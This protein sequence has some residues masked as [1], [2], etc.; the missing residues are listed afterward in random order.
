[1]N[2]RVVN[3]G[4]AGKRKLYPTDKNPWDI[5]DHAGQDWYE[6]IF[7]Y[8]EEHKKQLNEKGTLAGI[9]DALTDRLVWDLDSKE[10]LEQAKQ[11]TIALCHRLLSYGVPEECISLC[12]SGSKGF[13]VV[14]FTDKEFN[15]G[16]FKA[17]NLALAGDL[18]TNDTTV[19]DTQ[20]IFRIPGTKHQVTGLFKIPVSLEMLESKSI[21]EIKELAKDETYIHSSMSN[22]PVPVFN[23]PDNIYKL[24]N[25]TASKK[26]NVEIIDVSDLDFNKK[27]RGFTNCK[28]AIMNGFF[29]EGCRSNALTALAA[30][31]RAQGFS[32][33]TTWGIVKSAIRQQAKRTNTEP[34]GK[35][36]AW[37]TII[38]STYSAT[39]DGGQYSC[40]VQP[41]LTEI[42]ESLGVHKCKHNNESHTISSDD[43][44]GLFSNYAE[45]YDENVL[46]TGIDELDKESKFLVGTS[47]G[48][49]A[50]PGVG[51]TSIALGILNHN[52]NQ[53]IHSV[54]FSYDMFHSALYLR[55]IQRH[56][57]LRQDKIFDIFKHDKKQVNK[58]REILKEEYKNVHFCFKSGQSPDEI[59]QTIVETEQ[60]FGKVKLTII[61][62]NE[63]VVASSSDPTQASAQTAQRLRQIA[64]DRETCVITLLQPNKMNSNPSNEAE[65]YQAA[66]GSNAIAQSVTLML[67]LSRP[68]FSTRKTEQDKFFSINA[69]KNRMG[70]LFAKDFYWDGLT[71]KIRS[72]T[73]EE[74]EELRNLKK[75]KEA[76]KDDG[77]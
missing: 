59:E 22:Y 48:I 36:E 21:E 41:W 11:D 73:Y 77:Y 23:L 24:K 18:S 62:Y 13:S 51:K 65:T 15:V 25:N 1:M 47:N 39:W 7:K 66:K 14:L 45:H 64:N 56:F 29:P 27:P 37:N 70:A 60:K 38:K 57:G 30:T 2:Y 12:F 63:L 74:D 58:W 43:V 10:D 26:S 52:S 17:I 61:D 19:N 76:K 42:C 67:S 34:F 35:E 5:I 6:S 49:L 9:K 4:T 53:N 50:P 75:S 32:Q 31:C 20:R 3:Q 68:G 40:R 46:N 55:L 71:G 72:L 16:E 28:F 69:L 8:N 54:F 33:D 44:F